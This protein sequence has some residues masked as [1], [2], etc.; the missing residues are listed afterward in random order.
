MQTGDRIFTAKRLF[1]VAT[2]VTRKDDSIPPR[3]VGLD[4]NE[5]V[6]RVPI[7]EFE[8]MLNEYYQLRDW[9]P[10]GRPSATVQEGLGIHAP[11]ALFTA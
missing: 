1:N 2:G 3:I 4:R 11:E 6:R 7:E 8:R 5:K 9:D 10:E